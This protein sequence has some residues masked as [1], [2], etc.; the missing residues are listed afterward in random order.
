MGIGKG[1]GTV[2]AISAHLYTLDRTTYP[3]FHE[4]LADVSHRSVTVAAAVG[5]S[6]WPVAVGQQATTGHWMQQRTGSQHR[7][8]P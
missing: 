1:M 2:N 8:D 5:V 7:A 3:Q 4:F 6:L